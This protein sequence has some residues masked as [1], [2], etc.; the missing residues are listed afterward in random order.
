MA[1]DDAEQPLK[2]QV[3]PPYNSRRRRARCHDFPVG[4]LIE[5][6]TKEEDLYGV[7]FS[8]TVIPPP[9]SP[10]K[11]GGK[12]SKRRLYVEYHN[13][14][15]HDDRPDRLREH[16][17]ISVVRPAPPLQEVVANGFV[18]NDVVDAF[19]MDGWWTGV[20]SRAVEG[21]ERFVVTFE[22]P[23]DEL[24]FGLSTLRAHWDWVDGVWAGP[25]KQSEAG[26]VVGMKVEVWLEGGWFAATIVEDLGNGAFLVE[27]KDKNGASVKGEVAYLH[28]RPSPPIIK[29]RKFGKSEKV[30]AFFNFGWWTGMVAKKL[31]KN[32]YIVYFEQMKLDNVFDRS[33]MRPYMDWK[34]G[35][36][37]VASAPIE[38]MDNTPSSSSTANSNNHKTK[39]ST[40][41]RSASL[42]NNNS[43]VA[44]KKHKGG[45]IEN[46]N[47]ETEVNTIEKAV[48]QVGRIEETDAAIPPNEL[49]CVVDETANLPFVKRNA[50]WKAFESVE[51]FR[52]MPQK[53]HFEPL[54]QS[55][56]SLREGLAIACMVNFT[57]VVDRSCSLKINDPKCVFHDINETLSDLEGHGFDVCVVRNRMMKL[58]EAKE[59]EEELVKEMEDLNDHISEHNQKKRRIEGEIRV[60]NDHL[61]RLQEQL[62]IEEIAKAN[63]VDEIACLQAR[64]KEIQGRIR[65]VRSDFESVAARLETPPPLDGGGSCN[66][67]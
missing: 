67:S 63:E 33:E 54:L 18:P 56:E 28:V 53:P 34:D 57:N 48:A 36:W 10:R 66:G 39:S 61:R 22:N 45:E 11:S 3:S 35:K 4:S 58:V 43:E 15:A 65:D 5:V 55:K 37:F 32:G 16:V 1:D 13:L 40:K 41:R 14:L 6:Q 44:L 60:I 21:G 29:G 62:S 31:E 52:T 17:D 30:E 59:R 12:N 2:P 47:Q 23:P 26:F 25:E 49:P 27:Y 24:E 50:V 64:F 9:F 8:A 51:I 20:V 7:Y 42:S 19:Y 38:A 46:P